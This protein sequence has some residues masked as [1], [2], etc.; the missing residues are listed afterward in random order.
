MKF[1]NKFVN[2]LKM[3]FL[4]LW[5]IT[6]CSPGGSGSDVEP[7]VESETILEGTSWVLD[8]FG[9]EDAL[10]AVLPDT[11]IT[12]NFA[13]GGINGSAGCNSYF[14]VFTQSGSSLTFG[15]IGST[16]MACP[17]PTMQQENEYLAA[18]GAV[19]SFTLDGD[20]L[21]LAYED[22][23]LIF[24]EGPVEDANDE[25][26]MDEEE[27]I[28][29]LFVGP[30]LVDCVG[31]APQECLQVRESKDEEWSLFYG[32]IIGFEYEPGYEYELRV[33]ETEIDNPAADASSLEVTLVAI[34][35]QKAVA[36]TPETRPEGSSELQG[37]SWVLTAFG[38][39]DNQTAVL[40][41]TELTLNFD[42]EQI[43]GLA[44]CN[45]YFADVTIEEDGTLST[46]L[47]GST[48]MAC[49][50][51]DVMQQESEF[52]AALAEAT[53]YTLRG[54]RL[55]L[56]NENGS[57]EFVAA[58]MHETGEEGA[59]VVD[60]ETAVSI[61]NSGEVVEIFQ[62]HSLDVTLTLA[63]GRTIKTVEPAIDDIFTAVEDC[64]EPCRDIM[65]ATE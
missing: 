19:S 21:T 2:M 16:K 30:E 36:A 62:T 31:V 39:N 26:D 46:G 42:G 22:G 65:M 10:T 32:Q 17:D 57:L 18:L 9:P 50:D 60:W 28:K 24:T 58:S 54:N 11:P 41:G 13:D 23:R 27:A 40:P 63:D 49:L 45:S 25:A 55:T 59:E 35:S 37:T 34:V 48:L 7:D 1:Q 33:T 12:L 20:Q 29:T 51:E 8:E 47:V 43:N 5:A 56:H 15:A 44:G 61:L 38:P 4:L 14:G 64:G 3:S 52:L 53:G 6:A